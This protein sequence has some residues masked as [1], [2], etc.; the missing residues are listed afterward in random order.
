MPCAGVPVSETVSEPTGSS[1][2]LSLARAATVT[3][4]A[5][6]VVAESATATGGELTA[7]AAVA[8]SLAA[9]VSDPVPVAWT[10]AT[11]PAAAV[12][13]ATAGTV[14]FP[15]LPATSGPS[16]QVTTCPVAEQPAGSVPGETPG[17]RV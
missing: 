11:A 9:L 10:E 1:G 7:S 13:S 14:A 17:G 5:W 4:V 12:L 3:G 6:P 15:E 2:S 8:V 16:A